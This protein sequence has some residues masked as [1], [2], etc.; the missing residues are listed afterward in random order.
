MS[1]SRS[2]QIWEV[3]WFMETT[4]GKLR[5]YLYRTDVVDPDCYFLSLEDAANCRL[6]YIADNGGFDPDCED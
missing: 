3:V 2:Q 1:Q 4:G 6:E 5:Q